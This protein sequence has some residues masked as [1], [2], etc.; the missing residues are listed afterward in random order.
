[1]EKPGPVKGSVL[2]VDDEPQ[3][4]DVQAQM[5]GRLGYSVTAVCDP[6]E[7]LVLFR[8]S[9]HGFDLV[10]ADEIMPHLRGSEMAALIKDIRPDIPVMII[11]AGFEVERTRGTTRALHINNV[12]LKPLDKGDMAAAIKVVLAMSRKK[13]KAS[14]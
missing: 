3:V 5:L 12:F 9:P 10:I 11:T 4:L 13:G 1:M 2:L 7:A 8:S 6:L 14:R